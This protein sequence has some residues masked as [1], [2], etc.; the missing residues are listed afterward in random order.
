MNGQDVY[1]KATRDEIEKAGIDNQSFLLFASKVKTAEGKELNFS[2]PIPIMVMPKRESNYP[3]EAKYYDTVVTG[4]ANTLNATVTISKSGS[5]LIMQVDIP[6][7]KNGNLYE[8][9][10]LPRT[11]TYTIDYQEN[12]VVSYDIVTHYIS[13]RY[14]GN[15]RLKYGDKAT[16]N[17]NF[18]LCSYEVNGEVKSFNCN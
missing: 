11:T 10:P 4:S 17:V 8:Q 2:K 5:K 13:S 1:T 16:A 18:K 6:A 7:D 12:R 3:D 9:F 15:D 14:S